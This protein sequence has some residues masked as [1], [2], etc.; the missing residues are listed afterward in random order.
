MATIAQASQFNALA[1]YIIGKNPDGTPIFKSNTPAEL[2]SLPDAWRVYHVYSDPATGQTDVTFVDPNSHGAYIAA[3]G[4]DNLGNILGP[5]SK[6]VLGITPNEQNNATLAYFDLITKSLQQDGYTSIQGGGHSLGGEEMAYVSSWRE[7]DVLVENAPN[8]QDTTG[9]GVFGDSHVVAITQTNDLVGNWGPSYSN[10]ITIDTGASTINQFFSGG[11]HSILRMNS[12]I[13]GNEILA[14]Q[15]L[16]AVDPI[17]VIGSGVKNVTWS[18]T[19]SGGETPPSWTT[20]ADG[21]ITCTFSDSSCATVGQAPDGTFIATSTDG[22]GDSQTSVF[23]PDDT[24]LHDSW[25]HS[26]GAHGDDNFAADGSSSGISYSPDGSYSTY[27]NDGQGNVQ[28]ASFTADGGITGD[29]WQ[30]SDGSHG[31]DS[32]NVRGADDFNDYGAPI[33]V[34]PDYTVPTWYREAWASPRGY[35]ICTGLDRIGQIVGLIKN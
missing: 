5:D 12:T 26:D 1:Y 25:Q 31:D 8:T 29:T 4:T 11:T 21:S 23:N 19:S 35:M 34:A 14:S 16:D 9:Q 28:S 15:G 24:L 17:A 27:T 10:T 33:Q 7:I 30:R 18:G 3:R 2:T 22:Q 6:I 20:N 32:F 13:D